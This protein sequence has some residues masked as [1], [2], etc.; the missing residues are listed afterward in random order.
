MIISSSPLSKNDGTYYY[1]INNQAVLAYYSAGL[2]NTQLKWESTLSRNYGVDLSLFRSRVN[3]SVD[4]YNNSSRDLL[5]NVPIPSTFG[6]TTQYQNIGKTSN[7]GV[8]LQLN[9]LLARGKHNFSWNVSYNMSFNRNRVEALGVN[10]KSF[11][12]AA[13][14]GVSVSPLITS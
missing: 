13:S 12:P 5:L 3:L 9:A 4:V 2:V 7:K 11:F 14:W 6:Y 1:G 8:D 10:Q